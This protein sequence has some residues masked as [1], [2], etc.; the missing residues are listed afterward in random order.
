M[1][2]HN[3]MNLPST[4]YIQRSFID[5]SNNNIISCVDYFPEAKQSQCHI[6]LYPSFMPY[7]GN[8]TNNFPGGL[9]TYKSF[10]FIEQLSLINHKPQNR[11]QSSESNNNSQNLS[12]IEYSFLSELDIINVHDD[13][14]EQFLF[15]TK[16]YFQNN[17]LHIN[18]KSLQRVTH[19]FTR[20][21]TLINCAKVNE[22]QLCGETKRS[23]SALQQY[24]P[25]AKICY[26]I[27]F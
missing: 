9:F 16:T 5:F 2:I 6:Y 12:V 25:Y 22:L 17:L 11:K 4:E 3:E 13:Y 20:D 24:F 7:Y 23:N 14:I 10:P 21:A 26:P 18:Y 19:N 15:D 1:V 8:I 27:I